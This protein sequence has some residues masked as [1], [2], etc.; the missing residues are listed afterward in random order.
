MATKQDAELERLRAKLEELEQG[1]SDRAA[2]AMSEN[3]QCTKGDILTFVLGMSIGTLH[4]IRAAAMDGNTAEVLA[5]VSD[6]MRSYLLWCN[7]LGLT[8]RGGRDDSGQ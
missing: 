6:S 5:A 3:H 1:V 8:V 2:L 7:A 4:R